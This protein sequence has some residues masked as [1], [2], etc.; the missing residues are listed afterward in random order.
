MV[1]KAL[2]LPPTNSEKYPKQ[3]EEEAQTINVLARMV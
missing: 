1:T 3:K 2:A